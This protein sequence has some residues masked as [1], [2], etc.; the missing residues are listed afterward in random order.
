[1]PDRRLDILLVNS[2]V[3]NPLSD[4]HARIC[5]PLGLA[6]IAAVLIDEGYSVLALDPNASLSGMKGVLRRVEKARPRILGISTTTE[7][8]PNALEIARAVKSM[9][10]DI[11]T[12]M[13][14]PHVSFTYE[15][16]LQS[17]YVDFVVIG[18]GEIPMRELSRAVLRGDRDLSDVPGL[19][20]KEGEDVVINPP[21]PYVNE[22]LD[23]LPFPARHLFPLWLYKYP[24]NIL[25]ARGCPF[26]CIYCAAPVL[27]GRRYRKRGID[28]VIEE[29]KDL[30][31]KYSIDHVLFSD[32]T[33]TVDKGRVYE[34]CDRLEDIG[35][36]ITWVCST[37]VDLVD[38]EL[39]RRM[40]EA[41]C[42]E[43][44]FGVESGSQKV[45]EQI[46]K[47]V[48]V[49]QVRAAVKWSIEVGIKPVCS[50]M[51]PHPSDTEETIKETI[52]FM[53]ELMNMGA[54]ITISIT[55]PFPGTYMY[56]HAS[57]LGLR[58]L[59]R[60]WKK[61]N[62]KSVVFETK[63]LKKQDIERLIKYAA[64]ELGVRSTRSFLISENEHSSRF[65]NSPSGW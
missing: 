14:G 53:K 22:D 11:V 61:Y 55:T 59:T 65:T 25:T 32:D 1:M 46:R 15:E 50:F 41:N 16:T 31:R 19:A 48:T 29:I 12:V 18:E 26:D 44:L 54:S 7:A 40:S 43:I 9:L 10:P 39:L 17:G 5:P 35:C 42:K 52:Q 60:D 27:C 20:R 28:A 57:E 45:L 37:R 63:Y 33:F 47:E 56:A 64:S 58:L 3:P 8:Y 36:P 6:Y 13:G 38:K 30:I 51:I 34:L 4:E 21:V 24:G 23:S 49:D 2:P 62:A